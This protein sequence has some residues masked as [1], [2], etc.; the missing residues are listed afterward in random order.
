MHETS[1]AV[2]PRYLLLFALIYLGW[3]VL[4][5]SLPAVLARQGASAT[6]VGLLLG[7]G[8]ALRLVAMPVAGAIA[9]R[10]G[11]ARRVLVLARRGSEPANFGSHGR[12]QNAGL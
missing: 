11:A 12:A 5:P 6:E 1:P 2:L 7:M 9:D 3:G 8:T 10:S 4:S